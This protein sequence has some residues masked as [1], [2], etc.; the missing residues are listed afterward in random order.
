MPS[1]V[2]G[3]LR[4][5]LGLDSAQ[6]TSGASAA[7]RRAE[8]MGAKVAA[9]LRSPIGAANAL[10]GAIAALGGAGIVAALTA[11]ANRGLE[12]ASS[13]GEVSQQLG[14]TTKDLQVYRYAASQVGISQ[15][16]IDKGLA[17]LTVTM[18]KARAGAKEPVAAFKQLS[19]LL[20]KDVLRSAET[21]GDA[22]PLIADALLKVKDPAAR[23]A[24]EVELFGK[25]GQKLDTLLAGGSAGINQLAQAAQHLGIIL[26][27]E[28]IRKADET[29]D[30]LSGL[31]TVL[32]A[33]IA[34]A[35]SNNASA[36]LSLA[37]ALVQVVI[38]LGK[39]TEAFSNF[40]NL[41]GYRRGDLASGLALGNT[42][43]GRATLLNELDFKLTQNQQD[44]RERR[45]NRRSIDP[46]GLIQT[47]DPATA[48]SDK[49]LDAKYRSLLKQRNAVVHLDAAA[50]RLEK[51]PPRRPRSARAGQSDGGASRARAP[52]S[53]PSTEQLAAKALGIERRYQEDL[54]RAND[55]YLSAKLD[56]TANETERLAI[57]RELLAND[58]AARL[59]RIETDKELN[60]EQKRQLTLIEN[61]TNGLKSTLLEQRSRER[62]AREALE[63]ATSQNNNQQDIL[64]AQAA[65]A[66]TAKERGAIEL[67]ILD[68]QFAQLRAEQ[69]AVI[70]SESASANDKAIAK[71]RLGNLGTLQNLAVAKSQRENA[72]PLAQ[73]LDT[74][75]RTADQINEALQN[76]EVNGLQGL[77]DG[78]DEVIVGTK[79][80]G[81]VFSNVAQ[82]IIADL[83]AIALKKAI[84]GPLAE[85]LGLGS[86]VTGS[87]G[88]G[89]LFASIFKVA[90][91]RATGGPVMA[92]RN[93]LVGERGPEL[94]SPDAA[95][96]IIAND[97]I[98]IGG[99]RSISAPVTIS[100]DATGADAAG[101]AR[102]ARQLDALE[103]T[104]PGRITATVADAED[105][106]IL[107][108][109]GR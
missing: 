13:L 89:S 58:Y 49:K 75:P 53:G 84:L 57:E 40:Y 63:L 46:L 15:E 87:A 5:V 86:S 103:A 66:R 98:P 105:R 100:I 21:A 97:D 27:D 8:Q 108:G 12:Y 26:S 106:R 37:N 16:E 96:R 33:N 6:F 9:A 28:Q 29:K 54:A 4:V 47:T 85:A 109:P 24:L 1:S 52:R 67:Q 20:G 51:L 45:G 71:S 76:V 44:R 7:E 80:I 50:A 99:G 64:S 56:L 18:G 36:I 74:V 68:L 65:L 19:D 3:A 101:L 38:N 32:E 72:G 30:N 23:A 88:G 34:G 79:S 41:V 61:N 35:V 73:Y 10:S 14:V 95:G 62:V 22:I 17:K 93:Y 31:K 55:E 59:D 70:D 94:F 107:R 82:Q 91:K 25:T 90:G 2:V 69:Q 92:G 102:V 81:E 60:A 11:A 104:L 43:S 42:K 48:A 39:A 83:A 78:L 77:I